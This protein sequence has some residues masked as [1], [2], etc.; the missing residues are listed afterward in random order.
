TK[1][2]LFRIWKAMRE[3]CQSQRHKDYHHYGGRGI[4][5]CE[6]WADFANFLAD[7]GPHPPG[8]TLDRTDNNGPYAPENCRWVTQKE[9]TRNTRRN[10]WIEFR[11]ERLILQDWSTRLGIPFVTL[12]RRLREWPIERAMTEPLQRP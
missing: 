2:P 3:R 12:Q 6:R 11:G 8:T 5:V 9:Q 7:M 4:T 10:I 1:T